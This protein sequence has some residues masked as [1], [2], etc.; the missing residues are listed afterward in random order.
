MNSTRC[1]TSVRIASTKFCAKISAMWQEPKVSV[2]EKATLIWRSRLLKDPCKRKQRKLYP[3]CENQRQLCPIG[4]KRSALHC[5]TV[6]RLVVVHWP[7]S[8]I[9]CTPLPKT[10][11]YCITLLDE[12][13]FH[14]FA[15]ATAC[16][17]C[18]LVLASCCIWHISWAVQFW[19]GL[20]TRRAKDAASD[21][22]LS[23]WKATFLNTFTSAT[24]NGH[25]IELRGTEKTV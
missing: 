19:W 13:S 2:L 18:S 4:E 24:K 9:Q 5:T 7:L 10:H 8:V 1:G 25:C 21:T 6:H 11:I 15:E 3:V 17:H 16:S 14:T 22:K 12:I 23:A 20:P